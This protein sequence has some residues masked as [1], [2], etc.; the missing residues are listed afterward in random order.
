MGA[1]I[2]RYAEKEDT[3]MKALQGLHDGTYSSLRE[4]AHAT[5]AVSLMSQA[6]PQLVCDSH[7]NVHDHDWDLGAISE[8]HSLI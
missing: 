5:G 6:N 3:V 2:A 8:C 1:N 4:A 7:I